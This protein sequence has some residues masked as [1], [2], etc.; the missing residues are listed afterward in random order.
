MVSERCSGGYPV[1]NSICR[2][3]SE[4]VAGRMPRISGRNGT[5][6]C[7]P[8]TE[9]SVSVVTCSHVPAERQASDTLLKRDVKVVA[10]AVIA[11]LVHTNSCSRTCD[12]DMDVMMECVG[13]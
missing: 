2:R 11:P 1:D 13:D 5:H 3:A 12:V 8:A 6:V 4:E 7:R 10:V 9:P